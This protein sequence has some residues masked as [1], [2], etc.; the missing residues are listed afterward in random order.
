[1]TKLH[2]DNYPELLQWCKNNLSDN[3]YEVYRNC[4][5]ITCKDSTEKRMIRDQVNGARLIAV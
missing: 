2:I 5:T 4:I 3:R 1:M